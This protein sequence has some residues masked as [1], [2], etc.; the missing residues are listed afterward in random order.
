VAEATAELLAAG[1]WMPTVM[2]LQS[3]DVP[4]FA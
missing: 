2:P 1:G 3:A 4:A